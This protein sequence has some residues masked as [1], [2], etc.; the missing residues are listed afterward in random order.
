MEQNE[1]NRQEQSGSAFNIKDFLWLCLSKWYLFAI[2]IVIFTGIGY[3]KLLQ[4]PK[5][6]KAEAGLMIKDKGASATPDVASMFSDINAFD[7]YSNLNNEMVAM[8]N[9]NVTTEVARRLGLDVD[10]LVDEKLHQKPLYG[11]DLPFKATFTDLGENGTA[12]VRAR[13]NGDGTV[14]LGPFASN[15]E[16]LKNATK[17]EIITVDLAS[18]AGDT[19]ATPMGGMLIT[20]NVAFTG[21]TNRPED[22]LIK[23]IGISA[24]SSRVQGG[25]KTFV[26]DNFSTIVNLSF[27]D[28]SPERAT[29]ILSEVIAVYGENWIEDRNQ[30]A[31]ATYNFINERLG[32]IEG[33]L[34]DVDSDI[35]GMIAQQQVMGGDASYN[36]G[37]N[38]Q[39]QEKID[40]LD[41]RLAL[42]NQVKNMLSTMSQA[43][44]I[45]PGT[46][47]LANAGID[48]KVNDYNN[49]ISYRNS[50]IANS[51]ENSPLVQ[52]L[53]MRMADR[54]QEI[55]STLDSYITGIR[56]EIAIAQGTQS[57]SVARMRQSQS[58]AP[59]LHNVERQQKVKESLY[60]YLLQKREENQLSQAFAAYNSKIVTPPYSFGPTGPIPSKEMTIWLALG[61]LL[62][63]A[64]LFV[65]EILNSR[66]RGRKDIEMLTIPFVGEIPFAGK[67][68]SRLKKLF[69]R[70]KKTEDETSPL[71]VKKGSGNV[72]NEAFRVIRTNLEFMV[73]PGVSDA[74]SLMITSA[75]PGSGKTFITLNLAAVLSLKGKS[76]AL[77]DLDLRKG[78][79]SQSCGNP[80]V[81]LSNYLVGQRNREEVV[82]RDV[83]GLEGVDLY[84]VGPIPPNPAELLYSDRLVDLIDRLKEE[85]DY[86]LIDCPPVEMVADAKIINRLVDVTV[87]VIRA[88]VLERGMLPE[89][90]RFYDEKRYRNLAVILNGTPDPAHSKLRRSNRF[91]YGY[92]YGYGYPKK[93]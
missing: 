43:Y 58:Q 75:N 83:L 31:V 57:Q 40:Q 51:S 68:Q 63:A 93:K 29:D 45:L 67:P 5:E 28:Y 80:A 15:T 62:P 11:S 32:V 6:Y 1:E 70:K 78:A 3:W 74:R 19:I 81:G 18:T 64:L 50:L 9:S 85:Y 36:L 55:L 77:V 25:L 88:G 23:R 17:A 24:A 12:A 73:P 65:G 66:V 53:D 13:W 47:A 10:Y 8:T 72:I 34:G 33:E 84:P 92:G 27:K 30:I 60:L 56:A 59:V 20:A 54:R 35:S 37:R 42:A 48:S 39:A 7:T 16:G 76:I 44:S 79:L 38:L 41:S 26:T 49:M 86:V 52:D 69:V 90:Q 4:M 71:L 14:T 89:I 91:G 22:I 46:G 82:V 2:S 21:N 87:F 61:L